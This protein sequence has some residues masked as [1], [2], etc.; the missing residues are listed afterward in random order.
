MTALIILAAG[1]SSR[2]GF[3]KQTLLYK[4]KT[5]IEIAVEAALKSKCNQVIVVLGAG[6]D[7]IKPYISNDSI[8]V[9]ENPDWEEGIASSI[10]MAIRFIAHDE[11]ITDVLFMLCDQPFVNRSLIDNLIGKRQE[12]GSK[13]VACAYNDTVGVPALFDRTLFPQLLSLK[14]QEGAK[15]IIGSYPDVVTTVPFEK[16]QIDIDTIADY[17]ELLHDL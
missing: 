14:G 3:P 16:G 6:A 17:E 13:I 15:K 11:S 10:R 12:T 1:S 9:I 5:L 2:L 4:G 8:Q 7:K